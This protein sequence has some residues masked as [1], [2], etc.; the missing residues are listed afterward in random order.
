MGKVAFI[1]ANGKY[2]SGVIDE[3]LIST[4]LAF[5]VLYKIKY[6]KK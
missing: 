2:F 5:M 3:I 1:A 6:K 4:D